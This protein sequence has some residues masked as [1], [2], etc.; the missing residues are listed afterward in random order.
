[1][2]EPDWDEYDFEEYEEEDE[3]RESCAYGFN[4]WDGEWCGAEV[5][6]G[7]EYCEFRCPF[8]LIDMLSKLEKC[9]YC[10]APIKKGDMLCRN[11]WEKYHPEVGWRI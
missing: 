3:E 5:R 2:S 9:W 4:P 10:N 1:M 7:I 8:R 11:C 6:L